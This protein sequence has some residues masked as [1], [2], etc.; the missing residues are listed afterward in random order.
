MLLLQYKKIQLAVRLCD[1][2]LTKYG[3]GEIDHAYDDEDVRDESVVVP[4]EHDTRV[5]IRVGVK[6]ILLED[7]EG[8]YTR[9]AM[10]VLDA[11]KATFPETWNKIASWSE[12]S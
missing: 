4:P 2:R 5:R 9:K 11:A 12:R 6:Y 7:E 8:T 1:E 3:K 10:F